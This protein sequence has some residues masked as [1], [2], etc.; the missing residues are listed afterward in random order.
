MSRMFDEYCAGTFDDLL[1]LALEAT[2]QK[3]AKIW[4]QQRGSHKVTLIDLPHYYDYKHLRVLLKRLRT[5]FHTG[6]GL[7]GVII[8]MGDHRDAIAQW[9]TQNLQLQCEVTPGCKVVCIQG[10][11]SP[12]VS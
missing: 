11:R 5:E 3:P 1:K 7:R 8:L 10:P 12:L 4:V 9:I 6:G 2:P